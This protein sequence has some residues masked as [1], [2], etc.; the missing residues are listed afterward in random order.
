MAIPI[1][2]Y[3]VIVPKKVLENKYKGGLIQYKTDCPNSSYIEDEYLTRVGFLSRQ[4]LSRFCENIVAN[5][6]HFDEE[7]IISEDYVVV[8]NLFGRNWAADWIG[9]NDDGSVYYIN[10]LE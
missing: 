10:P 6:L 1:G 4:A 8:Q 7:N 9:F 2:F 5:G 3:S